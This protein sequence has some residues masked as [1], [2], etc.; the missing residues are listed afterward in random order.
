MMYDMNFELLTMLYYYFKR[1]KTY[2][3]LDEFIL[4]LSTLYKNEYFL[5]GI[6][7]LFFTDVNIMK[8]TLDINKEEIEDITNLLQKSIQLLENM[9]TLE[10]IPENINLLY[11]IEGLKHIENEDMLIKLY[12]M[13]LRSISNSYINNQEEL[14]TKDLALIKK[15]IELGMIININKTSYESL[16]KVI[17]LMEEFKEAEPTIIFNEENIEDLKKLPN[18]PYY[19]LVIQNKNEKTKEEKEKSF[20]NRIKTIKEDEFFSNNKIILCKT[21]RNFCPKVEMPILTKDENSS[22]YLR[23]S[24]INEFGVDFANEIMK[25]NASQIFDKILTNDKERQ[26]KYIA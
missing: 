2:E 3:R 26:K 20:I 4:N 6:V 14:T 24:I 7:N 22:T 10:I 25:V 19:I 12:N 17:C 5:G 18:A 8:E 11:G 16:A 21:N 13:G 9:K 23:K 15:A 1:H